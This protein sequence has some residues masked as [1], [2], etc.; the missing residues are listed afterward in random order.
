MCN[1]RRILKCKEIQLQNWF[2]ISSEYNQSSPEKYLQKYVLLDINFIS[3]H[4]LWFSWIEEN[5]NLNRQVINIQYI[6][7]DM[8]DKNVLQIFSIFDVPKYTEWIWS[9]SNI[10]LGFCFFTPPYRQSSYPLSFPFLQTFSQ[11]D[12]EETNLHHPTPLNPRIPWWGS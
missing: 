9:E 1:S 7:I 4:Y 8:Q 10:S 5:V 12:A 3:H 6:N 2:K 11:I